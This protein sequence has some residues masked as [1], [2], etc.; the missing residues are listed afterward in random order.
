M[1]DFGLPIKVWY[2]RRGLPVRWLG[3]AFDAKTSAVAIEAIEIA[4]EGFL[5]YSAGVGI[6]AGL[7]LVI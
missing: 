1:N 2:F 5:Q 4:H 7:D 6:S 3:P